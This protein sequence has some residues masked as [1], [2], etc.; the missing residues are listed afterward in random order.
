MGYRTWS[1]K[2]SKILMYYEQGV[3]I[4]EIAKRV[5][6]NERS[7]YKVMEKDA[8]KERA[9]EF[10]QGIVNKARVLFE[11]KALDA[12]KRV[13]KIMRSGTAKDRIRFDAAKEILYQVGLK[14]V[15]VVETRTREYTPEELK[16]ALEVSR[17]VEAITDRLSGR[18]SEFLLTDEPDAQALPSSPPAPV[19]DSQATDEEESALVDNIKEDV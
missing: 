13:I 8:F 3:P 10:E 2:Y 5:N 15:D 17:E 1:G 14:P 7:V 16:S 6:M 9:T 4:A 11:A 19:P 18:S 12:A